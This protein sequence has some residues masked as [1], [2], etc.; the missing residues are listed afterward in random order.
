MS[1]VYSFDCHIWLIKSFLLLSFWGALYQDCETYGQ[2]DFCRYLTPHLSY[3]WPFVWYHGCDFLQSVQKQNNKE[4]MRAEWQGDYARIITR[5]LCAH[6][7]K[8]IMRAYYKFCNC[9]YSNNSTIHESFVTQKFLDKKG[10]SVLN[11]LT[12]DSK[13]FWIRRYCKKCWGLRKGCSKKLGQQKFGFQKNF[14]N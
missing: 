12:L 9:D 10:F 2:T 8:D 3:Q 7:D 4:I 14:R 11:I 13:K 6:N 5:R 1:S